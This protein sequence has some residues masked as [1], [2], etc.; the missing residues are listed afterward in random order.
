MSQLPIPD[1]FDPTRVGE[2]WKV[3]YAT[4]ADQARDWAKQHKL[5][6]ESAS[7]SRISL[8]LVDVQNTFCIP[9]FEL[10]VGGRSGHGAV[11]D[12]RRL[13]EFLYRN[14]EAVTQIL[15]TLDT[16]QATQ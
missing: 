14:L 12:N 4:R 13:C 3:D 5:E 16:H 15:P 9:G 2:I 8:L 7:K 1:F 11:D 10:F 6:A